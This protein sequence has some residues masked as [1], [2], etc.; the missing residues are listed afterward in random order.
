MNTDIPSAVGR[1]ARRALLRQVV[2]QA[3]AIFIFWVAVNALVRTVIEI[4]EDFDL[5][6]P[7]N[8]I[9]FVM[10]PGAIGVAAATLGMMLA[11]LRVVSGRRPLATA[12]VFGSRPEA[13]F[14]EEF[15]ERCGLVVGVE[16][17]GVW[18]HPGVAA[19]EEF[20]L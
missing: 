10:R 4:Y 1:L 8:T 16:A 6:V 9:N 2:V 11:T 17:T 18:E 13:E 14:A 7:V 15:R 5:E 3:L 19:A 20:F 12:S